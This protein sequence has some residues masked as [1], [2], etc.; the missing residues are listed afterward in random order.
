MDRS[1]A[2]KKTRLEGSDASAF[3]EAS[4]KKRKMGDFDIPSLGSMHT[5]TCMMM[6]VCEADGRKELDLGLPSSFERAYRMRTECLKCSCE[7]YAEDLI[8]K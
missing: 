4:D 8:A 1:V 3:K 5:F 6:Y 7:L 2:S